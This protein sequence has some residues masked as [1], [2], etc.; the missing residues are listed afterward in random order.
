MLLIQ[1]NPAIMFEQMMFRTGLVTPMPSDHKGEDGLCYAAPSFELGD[2]SGGLDPVF[3]CE[4][5]Q[6]RTEHILGRQNCRC[7][8]DVS[9]TVLACFVS[10]FVPMSNSSLAIQ[11]DYFLFQ[12]TV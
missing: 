9:M 12:T 10:F 8:F 7:H 5:F 1:M 3:I 2:I 6:E 11:V 4:N